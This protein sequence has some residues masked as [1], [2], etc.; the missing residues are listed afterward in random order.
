MASHEKRGRSTAALIAI[1]VFAFALMAV[2]LPAHAQGMNRLLGGPKG[3]VKSSRGE[4]L[5]GIMVQLIAQKSAMRTTVYSNADGRY[6]FPGLDA[7]TYTLRIARPLEFHPFVKEAVNINGANQLDDITLTRVTTAELLPPFPEIAAQ[8]TGSEWLLSLSGNGED[9]KLL[10][11]YCNWCHSYQ[12]IFRNR[13]DEHG[14]T[15]IVNRMTHGAGSPLIN[16]RE[17]GRLPAA[18]EARLVKWLATVRGPEAKDP[19]F[20]TLPRPQGRQTRVVITEYE[21]PRLELATH[22]VTGDSKGNVWYSPHRSSY[23]GRLDPKTGAVKEY[24]VPQV[25]EG[26]LP[27]THWIYVDKDDIVWGSE[28]WAH[29]I[30]RLDPKTEEFKRIVWKVPTPVNS[31]MGGNYAIDPEGFIWRARDKAVA[32][33]GALTGETVL[34]FPTKKFPG[35]YGSAMS[36]DGRYFGGG[37]WPMDGVIVADTKTGEVFEPDSSPTSGPARGEFDP[38]NNYW[39]GGRGGMLVKYDIAKKRIFEYRL[40]TPYAS[41]YSAQSDKNGEIWAGEMHSGRYLRFDPK[42]EQFTEYVLPEPYG[43]D[44][45]TWIDNS[46]NPVTVWYVDHDGWIVRIQPRD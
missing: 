31:P 6:E 40:P 4:P 11:T 21:L 3:V 2:A 33:I 16:M 5:E 34:K 9:K 7:G 45:E 32:K 14:W 42:T 8:L 41:M 24:R 23:I 44:R 30:W 22:D 10:T 12:Q 15:Q 20:V 37:A 27:G 46:T 38:F 18:D 35:T 39:A 1:L 25:P 36:K 26:V 19:S 13:Y 17:P 29:S 28:N 43:I